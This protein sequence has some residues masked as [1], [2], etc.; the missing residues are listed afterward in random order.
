M[1][2][3][4]EKIENQEWASAAHRKI[5]VLIMGHRDPRL[6][7]AA[8]S[9][10]FKH[11]PTELYE[12]VLLMNGENAAVDQEMRSLHAEAPVPA[13]LLKSDELRPG[14]ARSLAIP[15]TRGDVVLFLDDDV[16]LFQDVVSRAARLFQDPELIAAG[17]ANLTPPDSEPLARASGAVLESIWGT[18]AMRF[19]YKKSKIA[20]IC[21]EHYLILCNLAV[22]RS[23]L[24]TLGGFPNGHLV[25]NEE[26][27][28]LQQ[29]SRAGN[30]M[31][32][33][34]ELAVY[35]RRRS[36]WRGIAQ[37]S[38]KYGFGRAQNILL[39]P[40]TVRAF[41][42]LPTVLMLSL[43][44]SVLPLALYF[45]IGVLF[46][47]SHFARSR[48]WSALLLQPF[49]YPVVHLSYGVGFLVALMYWGWRRE[50]LCS[51]TE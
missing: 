27:V 32:T 31:R 8:I 3:L 20:R 21:N 46:S 22:R 9:S 44:W 7:R 18:L 45:L 12:L 48:D 51:A 24:L 25:S 39:Q 40:E 35:H 41:Y 26:N 42:F 49:V 6:L 4:R 23:A 43:V 38:R 33:D 14:F 11:C 37:Q 30:K 16:E 29:L 2:K 17:G 34:P 47:I 36:T 1:V 13:L 50:V 10:L 28:L 19:R 15:Y 5:S